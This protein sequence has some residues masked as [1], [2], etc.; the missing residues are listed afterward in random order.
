MHGQQYMCPHC[1]TPRFSTPRAHTHTH[2]R[3]D[4]PACAR[5]RTRAHT[6]LR[7]ARGYRRLEANRAVVAALLRNVHL[8]DERPVHGLVRKGKVHSIVLALVPRHDE[9]VVGSKIPVLVKMHHGP[10]APVRQRARAQVLPA[11][12]GAKVEKVRR[13]LPAALLR[14]RRRG[15][16]VASRRAADGIGRAVGGRLAHRLLRLPATRTT[17]LL[18]APLARGD[19]ALLLESSVARH[20]A[21]P[22]SVVPGARSATVS[23]SC[24]ETPSQAATVAQGLGFERGGAV[25]SRSPLAESRPRTAARR[26]P[27]PRVFVLPFGELGLLC[28]RQPQQAGGRLGPLRTTE[29]RFRSP[30]L[31]ARGVCALPAGQQLKRTARWS[32]PPAAHPRSHLPMDLGAAWLNFRFATTIVNL[33]LRK[34]VYFRANEPSKKSKRTQLTIPRVWRSPRATRGSRAS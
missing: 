31:H 24:I 23:Q 21:R 20:R 27:R 2:T 33:V 17:P 7:Q 9:A 13:I 11:L 29:P 28:R 3:A 10:S 34:V 14:A 4:T 32:L 6:H 8:T 22:R 25:P 26:A 1:S 30:S 19:F 15:A 12:R 18:L 16:L 5:T